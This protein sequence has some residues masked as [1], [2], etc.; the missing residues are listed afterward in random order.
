MADKEKVNRELARAMVR[1]QAG[2]G[3]FLAAGMPREQ[4]I[5]LCEQMMRVAEERD[6]DGFEPLGAEQWADL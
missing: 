2:A 4:W 1:V 3:H 6:A 5:T